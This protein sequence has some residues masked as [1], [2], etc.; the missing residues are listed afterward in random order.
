MKLRLPVAT[1][2]LLFAGSAF[3]ATV[4]TGNIDPPSV[5][6]DPQS[7][8][9]WFSGNQGSS[10]FTLGKVNGVL[11]GAS[12]SASLP[13]ESVSFTRSGFCFL[14][15]NPTANA[16]ATSTLSVAGLSAIGTSST[17]NTSGIYS[18][19]NG[20]FWSYSTNTVTASTQSQLDTLAA[21]VTGRVGESLSIA[22]NNSYSYTLK[23]DNTTS[24]AATVTYNYTTLNHANGSFNTAAIVND[25]NTLSLTFNSVAQNSSPTSLAFNLYNLIGSYG[26]QVV[27]VEGGNSQFKLNGLDG[28]SNLEAGSFVAGSVALDTSVAGSF[29]STWTIKVADSATGLGGGKNLTNTDVLTLNVNATVTPVPEPETYAMLLAGLGMMVGVARRKQ[30]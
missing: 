22:Q 20:T 25:T 6:T 26:L 11:T 9:Y 1:L 18:S 29:A 14:C 17:I 16:Y 19:S 12:F 21:G 5:Q 28:T 27:S 13:N 2:A 15:S 8:A 24:R 23:L 30:Q 7:T 10:N 3:S 4:K